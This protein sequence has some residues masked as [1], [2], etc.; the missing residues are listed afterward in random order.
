M[1]KRAETQDRLLAATRHIIIT[2]GIE[3][4]AKTTNRNGET[5]YAF[6]TDGLGHVNIMDDSNV[7]SLMA[8]PYLGYCA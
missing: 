3:A 6:E 5:I 4:H 7:P 2:E 8:A 1:G